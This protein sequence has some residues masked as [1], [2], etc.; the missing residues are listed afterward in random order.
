V[1]KIANMAPEPAR[2][3]LFH[4]SL[5]EE[6][7]KTVILLHGLLSSHLEWAY[8]I[9]RLSEYHILVPDL[10]GHSQS[11]DIGPATVDH[12]ADRV[13]ELIQTRAHSQRAHVV[14]LSFGGFVALRLDLKYGAAPRGG[15]VESLFITGAAPLRGVTAWL[16]ARPGFIWITMQMLLCYLPNAVYWYAASRAGLK[17]HDE[18]LQEMRNNLGW[19]LIEGVYSSILG[20][21]MDDVANLHARTLT[22]AG[23]QQ[24]DLLATEEMGARLRERAM[25]SEFQPDHRSHAVMVRRAVHAWD[26]QLPE[27]FADGI[28]AWIEQKPLPDGFEQL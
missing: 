19:E 4:L 3:Q 1:Y 11:K 22:V 20:I 6:R 17:R 7:E 23:G 26:L 10:C 16:A 5:N 18:L 14:G 25:E 12:A 9:P 27:L 13:A 15:L 28:I 24:D 21:T 8:V 2:P